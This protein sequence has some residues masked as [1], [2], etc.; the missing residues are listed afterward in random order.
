MTFYTQDAFSN[1]NNRLWQLRFF[2]VKQTAIK[3][4]LAA[5]LFAARVYIGERLAFGNRDVVIANTKAGHI[6]QLQ[7]TI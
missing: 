7:W 3:D 4:S 6:A 1:A 5:I 2:F